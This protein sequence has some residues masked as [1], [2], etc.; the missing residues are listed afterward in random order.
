MKE[1]IPIKSNVSFADASVTS[2]HFEE[3]DQALNIFIEAWNEKKIK[4]NFES[5]LYFKY[6]PGDFILDIY[7][8]IVDSPIVNESLIKEYGKIPVT[9]NYKLI[10]IND[11]SD[12]SIIQVVCSNLSVSIN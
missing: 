11:I 9:H 4:L 2:F 5:V 6:E 7:Q 1:Y 3:C 8:V 12:F 10:L